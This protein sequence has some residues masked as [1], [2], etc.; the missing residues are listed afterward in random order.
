MALK[1]ASVLFLIILAA[2]VATFQPVENNS[3]LPAQESIIS[4]GTVEVIRVIDGDTIEVSQGSE[5]ETIRL[6][7]IDAPE[8]R[9]SPQGA[10]CYGAEAATYLKEL[11]SE[12]SLVEFRFDNTQD[13]TDD[14]GRYLGYLNFNNRDLGLAMIESGHAQEFTF[15]KPYQQ[16]ELYQQAELL[17]REENRGIWSECY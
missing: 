11:L 15:V 3:T 14:Y 5:S 17:A 4:T 6:I 13:A 8:T 9:F 12:Q 16:Q 10:E 7:G 2:S 1:I